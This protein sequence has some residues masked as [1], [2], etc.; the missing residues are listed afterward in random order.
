MI[1]G[2]VRPERFYGWNVSAFNFIPHGG[3]EPLTGHRCPGE[4]ITI[5]LMKVAVRQLTTQ[6]V[7]EVPPQ[8][9]TVSLRRMPALPESRFIITRI[10]R[11][12]KALR[13]VPPNAENQR[14]L[15]ANS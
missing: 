14:P 4:W 15:P 11:R 9:L 7:Y 1:D 2:E 12:E 10:R 3:G 13:Q 5:E 6:L 8:N